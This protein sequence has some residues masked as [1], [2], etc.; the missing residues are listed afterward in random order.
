MAPF[1]QGVAVLVLAAQSPSAPSAH[2]IVPTLIEQLGSKS[3]EDREAAT[4]ALKAAGKP[5]LEPLRKAAAN[6]ADPEVKRRAERLVAAIEEQLRYN[7]SKQLF[8]DWELVR[9]EIDGKVV[10]VV[11]DPRY[12]SFHWTG[13]P[14]VR[15]YPSWWRPARFDASPYHFSWKLKLP[16]AENDR[17]GPQQ[18]LGIFTV[19]REGERQTIDLDF[20]STVIYGLWRREEANLRL[21]LDMNGG[22]RPPNFDSSGAPGRVVL[23][24]ERDFHALERMLKE[25]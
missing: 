1:L 23:L 19:G 18:T 20:E 9:L 10:P 12:L 4:A 7:A 25:L 22:T 17:P 16:Q 5:A 21:C 14:F 3:F 2:L 6:S 24:F 11:P 13:G 15:T 8:G